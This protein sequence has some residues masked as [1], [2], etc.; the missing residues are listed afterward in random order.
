MKNLL[1]DKTLKAF[2]CKLFG[3]KTE[4]IIDAKIYRDGQIVQST[5][6]DSGIN[7][8]QRCGKAIN[9]KSITIVNQIR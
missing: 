1:T 4:D 5:S 7:F 2:C 8:C 9:K 6:M 3:H